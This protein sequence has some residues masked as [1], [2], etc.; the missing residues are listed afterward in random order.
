MRLAAH[1]ALAVLLRLNSS[2][3]MWMA[4]VEVRL[5]RWLA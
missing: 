1:V 2:V 3:E 5:S 4:V